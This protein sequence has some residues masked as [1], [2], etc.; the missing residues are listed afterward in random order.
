MHCQWKEHGSYAHFKPGGNSEEAVTRPTYGERVVAESSRQS[1]VLPR[2]TLF[3]F[4]DKLA[5]APSLRKGQ[6][7]SV[8]DRST[9]GDCG[10]G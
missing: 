8:T 4:V 2:T 3:L 10:Y 5:F 6:A 7:E 9:D 1:L